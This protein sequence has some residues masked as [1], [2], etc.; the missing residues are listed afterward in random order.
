MD[1]FYGNINSITENN[2]FYR[3]VLGTTPTM[4]LVVMSILTEIGSENHP[5][6]SQFIRIE[7]GT[8]IAIVNNIKY[9]LSEGVC[10]MI[11]PNTEHNIINT[12]RLQSLKLYTL[13]SPPHH[14]RDRLDINEHEIDNKNFHI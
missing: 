11:P 2:K 6:T 9:S 3:R 5:Y 8:G 14:P 13:Y 10:I 1:G 12:S 4:Q 7:N